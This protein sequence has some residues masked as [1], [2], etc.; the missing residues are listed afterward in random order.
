[1]TWNYVMGLVSTV[2]LSLPILTIIA[3]K[4]SGYRS[5]P[6]LLIYYALAVGDNFLTQGYIPVEKTF[7]R[8]YGIV[9]ILLETPLILIFL[10]YF[11]TTVQFARRINLLIGAFTVY[12]IIIVSI[13]GFTRNAITITLGSG[14]LLILCFCIHFFIHQTKIAIIHRKATGKAVIAGSFLFYFG[15]L[16]IIYLMY[17]IFKTPRVET[18]LVYFLVT[19]LSSLLLCAG[20]IIE[21]KRVQK[22]NELKITRKELSVV[23]KDGEPTIP[24]KTITLDFDKEQ[25]N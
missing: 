6:A 7:T 9:N 5:F 22:L 19:T 10:S 4:L 8:Y 18:F 11:S 25:W 2:A 21:R 16:S 17:Y 24:L 13:L 3:T 20:I 23:Y 15:C 14:L 12:E 1:M